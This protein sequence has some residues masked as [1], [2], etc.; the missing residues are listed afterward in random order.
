MH[1]ISWIHP[2]GS[3][4]VTTIS[5]NVPIPKELYKSHVK[6]TASCFLCRKECNN[7]VPCIRNYIL[8][9]TVPLKLGSYCYL[10]CNENVTNYYKKKIVTLLSNGVT[11]TLSTTA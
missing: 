8:S 5:D 11:V 7:R 1:L 10:K 2:R 4:T 3:E 6:K 9:V